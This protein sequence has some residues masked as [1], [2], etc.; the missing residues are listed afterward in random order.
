M[1]KITAFVTALLFSVIVYAQNDPK[2]TKIDIKAHALSALRFNDHLCILTVDK[3]K[4]GVDL[5]AIDDKQE[6]IWRKELDTHPNA[7]DKFKGKAVIFLIGKTDYRAMLLD[8][9]NGGIFASG[10][11]FHRT[12]LTSE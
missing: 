9:A 5:I 10:R 4:S 12:S 1:K 3:G 11:C 8:P 6:I 2:L 7:V